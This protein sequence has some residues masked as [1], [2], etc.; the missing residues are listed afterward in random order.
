M[1][2]KIGRVGHTSD[3]AGRVGRHSWFSKGEIGM[4]TFAEMEAEKWMWITAYDKKFYP[5]HFTEAVRFYQPYI[6]H[7]R[8]Q[9]ESARSSADLLRRIQSV[10][11][12]G[13]TQMLR[14]FSRYVSLITSV[15]MLNVIG[16]TE[17][18]IATFGPGFREIGKVRANINRLEYDDVLAALLWEYKDR[19][20]VG[21][22]LTDE[23]FTWFDGRFSQLGFVASGPRRAGRDID[24]RNVIPD[25]IQKS[26]TDIL[27]AHE[28][29]PVIVGW[30]RYDNDRGGAQED[31]RIGGNRE[32]ILLIIKHKNSKGVPL[33]IFFLQD[34]PGL[35]LGSMWRDY[36]DFEKSDPARIL[37][38]TL[39]MLPSR[40]TQ[41]WML[42]S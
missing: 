27:I 19:G 24:L 21:Y 42:G 22:D 32:K 37:V 8:D 1:H 10:R 30:G 7:F 40:L 23:F 38:A 33:K 36:G 6:D 13:R 26:P 11:Q 25:Y 34:G 28:G 4:A 16:N 29:E 3:A 12:P 31:D 2:E 15:Q 20:K 18:V 35:G 14:I 39:K 17:S 9:A 41:E 5:D